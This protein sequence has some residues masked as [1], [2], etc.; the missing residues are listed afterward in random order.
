MPESLRELA[1]LKSLDVSHNNLTALPAIPLPTL[2]RLRCTHN[3]LRT[4]PPSLSACSSLSHLELADNRLEQ[5]PAELA[6]LH[7]LARLDVK[8]NQLVSLDSALVGSARSLTELDVSRNQLR[9]LPTLAPLRRVVRLEL[10]GN[11]LEELP[12]D[13]GSMA[14]L[15][16]LHVGENR[17]RTLPSS[18]GQLAALRTLDL[19][20]IPPRAPSSVPLAAVRLWRKLR[21]GFSVYRSNPYH[22]ASKAS[23]GGGVYLR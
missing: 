20:Y 5:L 14:G 12:A 10:T 22:R 19:R 6:Q 11:R 3:Q 18:V 8:S 17:L 4:L 21:S 13:L 2:V 16:E 23:F 9:R 1:S 15:V 7:R